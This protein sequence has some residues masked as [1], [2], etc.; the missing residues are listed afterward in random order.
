MR[1]RGRMSKNKSVRRFRPL[2]LAITLAAVVLLGYISHPATGQ[3]QGASGRE[4]PDQ[5]P[6]DQAPPR[7]AATPRDIILIMTDDQ[8]YHTMQFMPQTNQ[9]LGTAGVRFTRA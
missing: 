6:P 8:P 4:Q 7:V 9:L 5:A 1:G 2:T 3:L